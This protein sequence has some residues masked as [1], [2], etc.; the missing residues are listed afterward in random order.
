ME[1]NAF[2]LLQFLQSIFANY[3]EIKAQMHTKGQAKGAVGRVEQGAAAKAQRMQKAEYEMRSG[4][5]KKRKKKLQQKIVFNYRCQ[6][7]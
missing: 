5:E 7:K 6:L 1:L 2:L 3:I 4:T